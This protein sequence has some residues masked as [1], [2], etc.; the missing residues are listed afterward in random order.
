MVL[1]AQQ[2]LNDTYGGVAG[3]PR[4]A[5]DGITGWSTMYAL[6]RAL[7]HEL[8]ITALSDS[9]GPT[10]LSTL[11][12]RH[13]SIGPGSSV[14][15]N[16]V[17]IIQAAL[18]C[19]GYDGG[20]ALMTGVRWT[21]VGQFSTR[22]ATAV[23]G[24]KVDAGVDGV[25]PGD[26]V[27]PKLFKAMLTM[28]AY[29]VVNGGSADVRAIQ[30]WMNGSY[31]QRANFFVIPCDGHVSRDVQKSLMLAVQFQIGMT[32]AQ[33]NGTFGPATQAGL[34]ANELSV[35][36][37]GR[38]VQI[39][40]AAMIFNRRGR[41]SFTAAFDTTL[42][43]R[44]SEFQQFVRLPLTRRGDYQTWA[45]LLVSTGD[46]TRRGT[47]LDC[48]TAIND[49]RAATLVAAGYQYVG[50]YLSNVP[51]STLN[52]MIQPGELAAIVRNGLRVFPIYQTYGGSAG[53]F[54][55]RQGQ[56]DAMA[57]VEWAR[58]HGF[59]SG[60][61]I[62]FAVDFDA[63]DHEVT[64][65]VLPHFRSL[66]ATMELYGP[67]YRIG[68]Y[69]PRNVC[70]RVSE[71]TATTASF[72]SDMSTGYSGN[73][74]HPLPVDWAFD[75]ISTITLG[76]GAGAIT[77]DND[78]AS[79]LDTGQNSFAP[80]VDDAAPDVPWDSSGTNALYA[81][82]RGYLESIG[83]PES[84]YPGDMPLDYA[85]PTTT[86]EALNRTLQYDDL[87]TQLARTL[88]LRKALLMVPLIWEQR[89]FNGLDLLSDRGVVIYHTTFDHDP[90]DRFIKR[91]GSTGM[92][93]VFA[94]NG[95]IAG[96][97]RC[98]DN[99]I[100]SGIKLDPDDDDDVWAV[101]QRLHDDATYNIAA[102][103]HVLVDKCFTANGGRPGLTMS[104]EATRLTIK[105]Y[106]GTDARAEEHSHKKL[107][108]YRVLENHLAPLRAR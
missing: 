59:K 89:Y 84:G 108:L 91:D 63:L 70:T 4:V 7:Q 16:I 6:T 97:N 53:Y 73:L 35:G 13:P 62:Y 43:D 15:Q 82:V 95:A 39:F 83:V 101:W 12:S 77:I 100:L 42:A 5:E 1:A 57:A 33:A 56:V 48:T 18:Y 27:V 98:I 90:T 72:V 46:P 36:S 94:G 14:P 79:G 88:Q 71:V 106:Q 103:A 26:A 44:V 68:I 3:V 23:R 60:T 64:S 69:G 38:W 50:R 99:G 8:G 61:R 87:I 75:Q 34:R 28:D 41:V 9:F 45:S 31:V 104:D 19:K 22:V 17:K 80:R 78:I 47:A 40:T 92:G 85:F 32:D 93:Q 107:G 30:R 51:G 96:R 105:L 67:E 49:A 52:K 21:F 11:T 25:W 55:S 66:I 74:G 58:R 10:T 37:S 102:A 76:S 86:T 2:F 20:E 81:D 65:N 29:V 24:L 54:T